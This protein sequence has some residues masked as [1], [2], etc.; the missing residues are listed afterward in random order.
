MFR[1]HRRALFVLAAGLAAVLA[2]GSPAGAQSRTETLRYVTGGVVNTLD[3]VMLGAT[4]AATSLGAATYDRL[5]AFER[6]PRDAAAGTYVFDFETLRGEL[7]ERYEVSDD[8]LSITFHLRP[9]AVWQDGSPVTAEDVKWSL[10]RAVSAETMSKA[11]LK[12]GSLTSP[13]QFEIVDERTVRIT[14]PQVDRLT[15]PNLASL[16]APVF[17]SRL[18]KEQAGPDDPWGVEWLKTHTAGSGAYRVET[19]KSGQQVIL[20]R[21]DAWTGGRLPAFP[22]VIVQTVPDPSSRANLVE[23]GDADITIDIQTQDLIALRQRDAVKVVSAPMPTA[24]T[25]VIFNTRMRPFDDPRVRRAVALALPYDDMLATAVSGFGGKLY[26]AEWD[27]GPPGAGF[28]Q[29][30]PLHTDIERARKLLAEA[31]YPDGFETT[32]SFAV[33]RAQ[34]AEPAAAL[35]QEALARIGIAVKID[36]LPDPQM[37]EAITGKRLPMLLERSFAMFP[38][39]EYFFRIFL[40]GP[41]RWNFASWENPEVDALL[42][43]ARAEADQAR[44]DALAKT[45]IATAADQVPMALLWQPT[46]DVVMGKDITGFTTW[47]HYYVDVRDLERN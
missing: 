30:L 23:R 9:D 47:Y 14:L 1:I 36:K 27:G 12:T 40:S 38:S 41:S 19:Y 31:G 35:V 8:G 18:V 42:P 34:W 24:F 5:V 28:P 32:L 7:A 15:L 2:S 11:Q 4:P 39:A 10:D 37:A 13:D 43:E 16:Y 20:S 46:Q 17:N 22:R 21:N 3:P 44:Y 33:N 45:L 26:G 25:A 6:T 29:A